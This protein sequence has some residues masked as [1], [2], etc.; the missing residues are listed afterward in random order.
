[1]EIDIARE[2]ELTRQEFRARWGKDWQEK[3]CRNK[4]LFL[5]GT[6]V[7]DLSR[8]PEPPWHLYKDPDFVGIRWETGFAVITAE[9]FSK[10]S[11]TQINKLTGGNLHE[12]R[13][14]VR[15]G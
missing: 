8:A 14:S 7:P 4:D 10:L 3:Y 6:R 12:K 9:A 5:S 1:M 11:Q 2:I 15:R 13:K